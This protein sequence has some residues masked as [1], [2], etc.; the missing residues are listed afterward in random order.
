[1]IPARLLYWLHLFLIPHVPRS[2][3]Y[4]YMVLMSYG[5]TTGYS[6][7]KVSI[8]HACTSSSSRWYHIYARY[9]P[10]NSFYSPTDFSSHWTLNALWINHVF[11]GP[12]AW[13]NGLIDH[14]NERWTPAVK[15][16]RLSEVCGPCLAPRIDRRQPIAVSNTFVRGATLVSN[17][18]RAQTHR[19]RFASS[20]LW[21]REPWFMD[22]QERWT[23][24]KEESKYFS[25]TAMI[26]VSLTGETKHTC[27]L[28]D[29]CVYSTSLIHWNT[30]HVIIPILPFS[31]N[32][33]TSLS[34]QLFD[35]LHPLRA[36][37]PQQGRVSSAPTKPSP[38]LGNKNCLWRMIWP[39]FT[40]PPVERIL[41]P[42]C[43]WCLLERF[44]SGCGFF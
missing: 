22:L 35:F 24:K 13:R 15:I 2:P 12:H 10:N 17:H 37:N 11:R 28:R 25:R 36:H 31:L 33:P 41:D 26:R 21:V 44:T 4:G 42:S 9:L 38:C 30:S 8:P 27:F 3:I 43:R 7:N 32:Q 40:M 6:V 16:W 29:P 19:S 14:K 39:C 34:F 1:M 20:R 23:S 5:H 18:G